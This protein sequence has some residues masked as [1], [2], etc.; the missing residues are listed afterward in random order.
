MNVICSLFLSQT[1]LPMNTKHKISLIWLNFQSQLSDHKTW[2]NWPKAS[3]TRD[4][5]LGWT[6]VPSNRNSCFKLAS[7]SDNKLW[8]KFSHRRLGSVSNAVARIRLNCITIGRVGS[9]T[10]NTGCTKIFQLCNLWRLFST[11]MYIWTTSSIP[12]SIFAYLKKK[13]STSQHSISF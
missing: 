9:K 7:F 11:W 2:W 13:Q 5:Y 12:S 3:S 6:C 4:M 1:F 10:G 8:T